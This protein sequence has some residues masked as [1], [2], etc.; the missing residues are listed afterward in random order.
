MENS[1][2]YG[3]C[4][5]NESK[6]FKK[7]PKSEFNMCI[8]KDNYSF[9][10][11]TRECKSNEELEKMSTYIIDKDEVSSIN[12]YEDCFATCSKCSRGGFSFEEQNCDEC[13]EGYILEGSNCYNSD[14]QL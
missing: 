13:K 7:I 5:C 12:I 1:E 10:K 4:T 6:G 11:N 14:D 2:T 9:Y 3:K 8:C